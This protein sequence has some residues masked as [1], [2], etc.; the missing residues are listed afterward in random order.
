MEEKNLQQ[1]LKTA[2]TAAL[3]NEKAPTELGTQPIGSLLLKY[4]LPA[5]IAMTASSL[6]NNVDRIFIG[7]GV[8]PDAISGLATTFP[9]MN[10]AAAFG[11]MIGVGASA[12]IS[13]RLGQKDYKTAQN[14]LGNT[15]IFNLILGIVFTA[16][17]LPF[18]DQ[19]LLLFGA[20]QNT[21]PYARDY[22]QVILLGNVIS[23]SYFGLNAVLRSAGHP[24]AA[25]YCTILTVVV[26]TILDPLF[27]WGFGMGIRGAAIA[28]ILSQAISLAIQFRLFCNP[29]EVLHLRRGIYRPSLKIARQILAIGASPFLMNCCA[30]MVVLIINGQMRK[31]GDMLDVPNGG[32]MAIA[33]YGITN[34][35]V[36]FFL[37]VVMGF[38]QGM[39]PIV[40]FNWGA[41]QNA[42]VW[43]CLRFTVICATIVSTLGFA[44]CELFPA[45]ITHLF[46]DD[47]VITSLCSRGFR[48][49]SV[50][51]PIV[52]AQ[53]VIGNFF[54]SIGHAGKSIFLS[55]TRQLLFLIPFLYTLP[56]WFDLDGVWASLPASDAIS[57]IAAFGMLWWLIQST[58]K[59]EIKN[60]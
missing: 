36:F 45:T 24:R 52:G 35:V 29:H 41:R 10:L 60:S 6:Y 51:L 33:A 11:A 8:G 31:Y 26:N 47:E 7:Q 4:A 18:L 37:M 15:L 17:C 12:V 40:G 3:D 2:P 32:D 23:H 27:I 14:V 5:I 9:F 16:A 39:Q 38:N 1:A 22:M 34:S 30:C 44:V 56:I 48:V 49:S 57:C 19:I 59:K 28:T 50:M 58:R 54:Q 13:I 55:L 20:S 42:R 53:M 25:M 46:T 21:L 43:R